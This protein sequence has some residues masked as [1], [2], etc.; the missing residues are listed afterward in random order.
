MTGTVRRLGFTQGETRDEELMLRREWLVTNGLGGFVAGTLSGVPTRRYHGLLV[1]SLPT[2]IGRTNMLNHLSETVTLPDGTSFHL[3]GIER[4]GEHAWPCTDCLKEFRLEDGL[5]VWRYD[6]HGTIL[7]KRILML[8]TQ[9]TTHVSY[10]LLSGG[11]GVRLTLRPAIQFRPYE[12]PV[13]A[14]VEESYTVTSIEDRLELCTGHTYPPLRLKLYGT[15]ATFALD[16]EKISDIQYRTEE[17]RGYAHIG[18]LWSPGYFSVDV[19]AETPAALVCSTE[20]WDTALALAP[21]EARAAE[22]ERR[23]RLI[24]MAHPK[25]RSGLAAELVL[26]ADQFVITPSG[27]QEDAARARAAGEDVRSVIAGY[28][29]FTDWG[30]DTMISLEGLSCTTGRHQEAGWILRTFGQYVRDGLIP[31]MFPDGSNEGLYHTADASLWFFQAVHRYLQ[32]TDDRVT[33]EILLPKLRD[34]VEHHLRGTRYGIKV[35]ERDG[36]LR[37]GA[38]GYQ[39]TWMD[40]KCDG[41][42]VT[43]RRGKAVEINALWYNALR[44]LEAWTRENEGE[45]AARTLAAHADMCRRSFNERFWDESLGHL[46]DVVESDGYDGGDDPSCR[47]NQLFAIAL[48]HAVLDESRW[49]SVLNVAREKLLT[50][51][52]LRSLAQDHPDF[53]PTY[54]GDLKTRDAAYHQGTVWAWLIGPF[55]DAW[56]KAYPE[57]RAGARAMLEGFLSHLDD[58]CVGSI[59][60]VF[61]AVEPFAARGCV[62]QAWSVAEVLRCWVKTSE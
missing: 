62:A 20:S 32:A 39:L 45:E 33:L 21:E 48:E 19:T 50:P 58:V 57:D 31:N 25:A 30:R 16:S 59:G 13:R 43:P 18:E 61:D 38:E 46:F 44:L 22:H 4:M 36:L 10:Q 40:A 42:V 14:S 6:F 7:E 35:D 11:E 56:L 17:R 26:A 5:P 29:W 34:I 41:W 12:E 55:I 3:G 24:A 15:D 49:E 9:N 51:V 27:R 52:G 28:H 47:P 23:E 8:H 53:H 2:P 1:A 37:Q 60:E 54:H